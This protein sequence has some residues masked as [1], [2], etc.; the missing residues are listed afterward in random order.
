MFKIS[1]SILSVCFPFFAFADVECR[2]DSG[3]ELSMPTVSKSGHKITGALSVGMGKKKFTI[4]EECVTGYWNIGS[5]LWLSVVPTVN[6]R[7]KHGT[8]EFQLKVMQEQDEYKGKVFKGK[9]FIGEKEQ[10][11][12]CIID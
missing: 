10:D 4:D 9:V 1:I 7:S 12:S 8:P 2:S 11:V 3:F 5:R 6:C